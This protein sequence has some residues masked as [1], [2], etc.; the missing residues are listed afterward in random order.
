MPMKDCQINHTQEVTCLCVGPHLLTGGNVETV[1]QCE[2]RRQEHWVLGVHN[3]EHSCVWFQLSRCAVLKKI[4][5]NTHGWSHFL[6]SYFFITI[7]INR[8]FLMT[9]YAKDIILGLHQKKV[10]KVWDSTYPQGILDDE[11]RQI[12]GVLRLRKSAVNTEVSLLE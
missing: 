11:A 9:H 8:N 4:K 10:G 1:Q 7:I 6:S 3:L 5:V 12:T 2:W